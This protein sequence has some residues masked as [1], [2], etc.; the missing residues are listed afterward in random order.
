MKTIVKR[1]VFKGKEERGNF[2]LLTLVFMLLGIL[3]VT[4]L[5]TYMG[6]GLMTGRVFEQKTN[7]LYAADAGIQDG[8]WLIKYDHLESIITDYAP[9]DFSETWDYEIPEDVN[10]VAATVSVRNVWVPKDLAPPS[11]ENADRLISGVDGEFP[12]LIIT[13]RVSE[14][15]I[16]EDNPGTIEIKIQYYPE[17]GDELSITSL[18]IWLP[19]GFA[20][21][22]DLGS[23]IDDYAL[24]QAPVITDHAGGRAVVWEFDNWPFTG[25]EDEDKAAFPVNS[26]GTPLDPDDPPPLISKVFFNFKAPSAGSNPQTAAWIDTDTDLTCGGNPGVSYTWDGDIRIY[27]I[28]STAGDTM[29]DAYIAKSQLRELGQAVAGDYKA[30]GNSLMV[31]ANHD[32]YYRELKLEESSASVDDIPEDARVEAAY[33]YWSAWRNNNRQDTKYSD[34]CDDFG[35]WNSGSNWDTDSD[36]S[37]FGSHNKYFS[38]HYSNGAE[39]TRYLTLK[40][41]YSVDLSTCTPGSVTVS[42][43]QRE[44]G[45]LEGTDGLDFAFSADGGLTWSENIRAFRDDIG[46]DWENYS[47]V[48]PA[49]YLTDNFKIRFHMIGCAEDEEEVHIDDIIIKAL[50]PDTTA[51]FKIDGQTVS[52]DEDG[53]P[54]EGGVLTADRV[55]V[56]PNY[57]YT[58]PHGFSYSCYKDVTRLVQEYSDKAPDPA[59]NHPGNGIYSVSGVDGDTRNENNQLDQWGYAGWSLVIIYSS[60]ETRGHQLYLYDDFQYSNHDTNIDFDRDGEPGGTIKGFMVPEKVAGETEAARITVFAGEGDQAFSGDQFKLNGTALSD[61]LHSDN[62]WNSRSSGVSYDGIDIDTF[63][64]S[65]NSGLINEGDTSAQIDIPTQTDIWN[66]VYII[67]SFRSETTTGGALSYLIR[68]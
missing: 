50:K 9:Y 36:W 17:T 31:D 1:I 42:W 7:R 48:V 10:G 52:F 60:P 61:G 18:G 67:L 25:D 49:Q 13:S 12:K 4:P 14:V 29:V 20:Y 27:Q 23:S 43:R 11:E 53:E 28:T 68:N 62:V 55:Q 19:A 41:Q 24:N 37:L 21:R 63:S 3:I 30:L 57:D 15:Y 40:D 38:S 51:V 32:G 54:Q 64:V 26:A 5:V 46:S 35:E 8:T 33:F 47:Y 56:L 16:D 39:Y 66:M 44:E 45:Y 34:S 2:L 22:E 59:E 6:T 65:W 58:T